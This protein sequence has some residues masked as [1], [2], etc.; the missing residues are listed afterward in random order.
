MFGPWISGFIAALVPGLYWGLLG[1]VGISETT[2]FFH[3]V[4]SHSFTEIPIILI[5]WVPICLFVAHRFKPTLKLILS[6]SV[7]FWLL[8]QLA[9]HVYAAS[10]YHDPNLAKPSAAGLAIYIVLGLLFGYV[11][12]FLVYRDRTS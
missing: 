5:F 12:W 11:F 4:V 2:G 10:L 7:G 9:V 8:H 3:D 1:L 6:M